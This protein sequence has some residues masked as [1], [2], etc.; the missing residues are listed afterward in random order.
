MKE[1]W[2]R[3]RELKMSISLGLPQR[4]ELKKLR[5]IGNLE[6]ICHLRPTYPLWGR[7]EDSPFT[8]MGR[9]EFGMRG[10]IQYP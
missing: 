4:K 6:R 5:E 10:P 3:V 7:T 1:R 9:K 2:L 8:T